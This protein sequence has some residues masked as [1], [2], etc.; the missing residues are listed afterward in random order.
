MNRYENELK[1]IKDAAAYIGGLDFE[2]CPAREN[3][4]LRALETITPALTLAQSQ[5]I[6]PWCCWIDQ[7]SKVECT[8]PATWNIC[9]PPFG[10]EDNTQSC[11]DHIFHLRGDGKNEVSKIPAQSL[12][13]V[14]KHDMPDDVLNLLMEYT[15]N[16]KADV[17]RFIADAKACGYN[18]LR[19]DP[20]MQWRKMDHPDIE[21]IK[22]DGTPI[23]G[24]W[25]NEWGVWRGVLHFEDKEWHRGEDG[26]PLSS[27]N[28]LT[29]W[30]PLPT[31]PAEGV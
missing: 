22:K 16:S 20:A 5:P 29:H 18:L 2:T 28:V 6:K 19:S 8:N 13:D 3:M 24:C 11:N 15:R 25:K 7:E 17:E 14:E 23:L 26:E 12:G 1:V 9:W 21:Q 10:Y 4:L 30:M 31:E 27:S